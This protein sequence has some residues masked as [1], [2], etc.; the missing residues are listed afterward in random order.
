MYNDPA[1]ALLIS[2]E[3]HSL[4]GDL[5]VGTMLDFFFH[6]HMQTTIFRQCSHLV[7]S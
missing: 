4:Y 1:V 7:I 5:D 2:C 6:I 3:Q